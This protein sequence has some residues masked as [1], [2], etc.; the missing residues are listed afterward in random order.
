MDLRK[1]CVLLI[2]GSCLSSCARSMS[3]SEQQTQQNEIMMFFRYLTNAN[4][5]CASRGFCYFYVTQ[6]AQASANIGGIATGDSMCSA[7]PARPTAATFTV[8]AFLVGS[9]VRRASVSASVGDGQIDWVLL[10]NQEYRQANGT[11][12][13]G[14]TG[15]N[16]LF[17]FP[18]SAGFVNSGISYKTGM[19]TAWRNSGNDCGAWSNTTGN[20]D[21]GNGNVTSNMSIFGG[22]IACTNPGYYLLCVEQ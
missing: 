19:D 11:T 20:Q 8:K 3:I 14:I 9:T 16:R 4:F 22:T 1:F 15:A 2:A 5:S 12:V 13:I 7:D 21:L 6:A 18:L 10:A 17:S